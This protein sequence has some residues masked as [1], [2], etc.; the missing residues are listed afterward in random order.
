VRTIL[1][2]GMPKTGTTALQQCLQASRAALLAQGLLYPENPPGCPFNNH[3]MLL[4]GFVPFAALPRH[5]RRHAR[6]R[7]E[8]LQADYR[9]F[10]DHLGAQVAAARPPA[11][12]LS[13]ESLFRRLDAGGRRSLGAALAPLGEVT[14]A[15]YLRRPSDY[16]LS[17]LQ[18]RL[19][20]SADLGALR[21]PSA[22]RVLESYARGFG[23]DALRPRV[24]DRRLLEGGD[25]V[26]DF[27]AAH[28]PALAAAA[29]ALVPERTVNA[30][31]SAEA[32][33]IQRRYRQAFHPGADDVSTDDSTGLMRALR[34]A[35]LAA[36]AAK[37]RLR[38]EIAERLD[39]ARADPLWLRDAWGLVF[40]DFDY[41][42]LARRR[43]LWLP[44]LPQRPRA[45]G[46]LVT[47][48]PAMRRALLEAVRRSRWAKADPARRP[49]LDGLLRE[50]AA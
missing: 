25:I 5:V 14:V 1:H 50:P 31:A 15:A 21:V 32:M 30:S 27:F 40:P 16:F 2:I 41:A 35:E 29:A 7:P 49:W 38:P 10:L 24:Y 13:S 45:L 33:D 36:G 19:K 17:S 47:L 42:R 8:T 12:L 43:W 6:Y 23:R 37:P 26:R 28:L 34:R 9:A 11:V 22:R 44:R 20:Q 18:Q 46:D 48:D 4:F 3:R 39:Y